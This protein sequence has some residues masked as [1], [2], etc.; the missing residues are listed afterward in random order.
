MVWGS[1]PGHIQQLT[2]TKAGTLSGLLSYGTYVLDVRLNGTL[3][4]GIT[5]PE[6]CRFKCMELTHL[7][8]YFS[9]KDSESQKIFDIPLWKVGAKRRLN[10][11]SKVNTHRWTDRQ[12]HGH[13]DGHFDL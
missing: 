3:C 11:T 5:R 1:N 12:T 8:H 2:G 9:P 13:T 7:S 6:C 4:A 10:G